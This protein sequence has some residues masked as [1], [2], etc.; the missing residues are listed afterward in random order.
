MITTIKCSVAG[1]REKHW[2]RR[3]CLDYDMQ[4]SGPTKLIARN[5]WESYDKI[6][7]KYMLIKN[8]FVFNG[9]EGPGG[10]KKM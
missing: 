9:L 10:L 7:E 2:L 5:E 8:D 1:L 6:E 4:P 3:R